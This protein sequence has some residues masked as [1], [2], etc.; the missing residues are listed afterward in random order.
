M[1]GETWAD[2]VVTCQLR[3]CQ[4]HTTVHV[5]RLIGPL[6][7]AKTNSCVYFLKFHRD[8]AKYSA[9]LRSQRGWYTGCLQWWRARPARDTSNTLDDLCRRAPCVAGCSKG[10]IPLRYLMVRSRF[11]AGSNLSATSFE[12]VRA[13]STCRV[14]SNLLRTCL[15]PASDLSVTR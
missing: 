2:A 14:S 7:H 6:E 5:V 8:S 9:C 12:Q 15:R 11:E 4:S 10:Q 13:I 1:F 3:G